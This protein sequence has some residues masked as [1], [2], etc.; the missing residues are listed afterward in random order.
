MGGN[1]ADQLQP[2]ITD[3]LLRHGHPEQRWLAPRGT[4]YETTP[5]P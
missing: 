4:T 5:S 2:A 3:G 1:S